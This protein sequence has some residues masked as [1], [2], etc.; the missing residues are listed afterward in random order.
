MRA[1]VAG[2]SISGSRIR[3]RKSQRPLIGL[4][5]SSARPNPSNISMPTARTTYL[6]ADQQAACQKTLLVN[7]LM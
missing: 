1:P 5:I 6:H 2:G 3:I 7:M 4:F